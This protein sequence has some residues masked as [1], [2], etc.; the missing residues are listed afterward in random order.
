MDEAM[1]APP[2]YT[3]R[4]H[5][6]NEEY[7]YQGGFAILDTLDGRQVGWSKYQARAQET[8][9]TNNA[10][11]LEAHPPAP[12]PDRDLAIERRDAPEDYHIPQSLFDE[13]R[14]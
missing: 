1:N 11:P 2:R 14:K 10:S 3:V 7:E 8:A 9:D 13:G 4:P 12:T 5:T 6:P